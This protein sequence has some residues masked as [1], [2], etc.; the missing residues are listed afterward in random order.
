MCNLNA[1]LIHFS[2]HQ[3]SDNLRFTRVNCSRKF[4]WNCIT[5]KTLL[6]DPDKYFL[7]DHDTGQRQFHVPCI[8][9]CWNKLGINGFCFCNYVF[10]RHK[11]RIDVKHVPIP[12]FVIALFYDFKLLD[13]LSIMVYVEIVAQ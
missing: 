10:K 3:S 11:H 4:L 9:K 7:W 1:L 13:C 12:M 5:R 2:S 8:L 6:D